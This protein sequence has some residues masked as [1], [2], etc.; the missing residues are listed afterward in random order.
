MGIKPAEGLSYTEDYW[1]KMLKTG[2]LSDIGRSGEEAMV[3]LPKA[4]MTPEDWDSMN[5]GKKGKV[6]WQE[7]VSLGGIAP[8]REQSF[9]IAH[10]TDE[11]RKSGNTQKAIEAVRRTNFNYSELTPTEQNYFRRII[12]F[13]AFAKKNF[14]FYINTLADHPEKLS[15]Y[16]NILEGLESGSQGYDRE[17]WDAMPDYIK[18]QLAIPISNKDGS[19]SVMSGFG[20]SADAVNDLDPTNFQGLMGSLNPFL[21]TGAELMTGKS[22]FHDQDIVD[23]SSAYGY[24]EHPQWIKDLLGIRGYENA[25][26]NTSYKMKPYLRYML[27][28]TPFLQQATQSVDRMV[29]DDNLTSVA[30]PV[31]ISQHEL[32]GERDSRKREAEE[33]FYNLLQRKGIAD[34]FKRYYIPAGLKEKLWKE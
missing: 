18:D 10:F 12:P 30:I 27:E 11:F 13:Y 31:K 28:N 25:S 5:L 14:Q 7:G 15:K 8:S 26:G 29:G 19:M 6:L 1:N 2:T 34:S 16:Q 4:A 23:R 3:G 21:K 20:L 33:A 17:S 22:F 24:R 9:R 32:E